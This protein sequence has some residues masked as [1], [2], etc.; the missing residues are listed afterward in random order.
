MPLQKI[1]LKPGINRENTN[2]ANE[3][4]WFNCDKVRFRS[5]YP[6]K[7]GGWIRLAPGETYQGVCRALINWF[8]LSNNNLIGVGT[9]KKYYVLPNSTSYKDITPI[10]TTKT[11]LGNPFATTSGSSIVKVTVAAHNAQVGD[12]VTFSGVPAATIG[13]IDGDLFNAE[14]EIV[15]II[16]GTEFDID[17]GE[18]ATSTATG[19]GAAVTATFQLSIG[20]PVFTIGAGWGAGVW[21]GTNKTVFATLA[22]TSGTKN[23]LLDAVST[24]IN[25]DSTTG[26]ANSGFIQINSEVI[27]YTGITATSFT[28]CTR[29]ATISG[30]ATPAT[31]HAQPPTTGS[32]TPPPIYVYQ[33][34]SSLGTTGWGLASDIAFGVGQQLR[35]WSHDTFGQ[36]LL[37][38]PRGSAIYYWQN[39]TSTYPPAVLLSTLATNAGY[40]G[41][42]V[43]ANTNQILVSDV[44]RFVIA[45]G[46]QPYGSVNF[47]PMT[48]RWS[49]Q[50]TP[51][52]WVPSAT[53]QAGE[54]RLS[55][56]SYTVCARETRQ[57]ILIW[58][59]SAIY[60]MQYLG[61]PYVWGF[62][63]LMDNIS[64]ISP[65]ATVTA[66]NIT[67][68]M[69]SDKFYIYNG[70]VDTL[71]CTVRQYIFQDLAFDQRFQITSG[72]NEG[73][74]EVW[75]FYVSKSE[76][77]RANQENRSP[78]IDKYVV[79]NYLDQVWYYGSLN[80]T[81][82]MDSGLNSTPFAARGDDDF[83][84]LVYHERGTDN[85]ETDS[86]KPIAAFIESSD[87]DIGDGHNFGFVWRMLPDVNFAGST[88]VAP[89]VD[90]TLLPRTNAGTNY[91][92][93]TSINPQTVTTTDTVI[94]VLGTDNFPNSGFLL[95]DAEII[96]YTGRTPTSFTGCTRGALGT[97]PEPHV[98]NTTVNLYNLQTNVTKSATY[99]I[100][101]FTGQIYTRVRGR[102]MAIKIS[103]TTLGT[104]WQLGAPRMDVTPDG[105]R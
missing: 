68:W 53:N 59:D 84:S 33:V 96:A 67:F 73:F 43:P 26:F 20:L 37:I 69:G 94:P 76:L 18:V 42:E 72:T 25:V 78:T 31:A 99:P 49:G 39:N 79:F 83:G 91:R 52:D 40:V 65:N 87:F 23:V 62:N 13:G 5:G 24:T 7:I 44:S 93:L 61:P 81:A 95:I 41:S 80:R 50:E 45:V 90:I 19:G 2:Y 63:L 38:N 3:G 102:Q 11:P 77:T 29:G 21:N 34:V 86:P 100:E 48:V 32:A 92:G 51:Y 104:A 16:S 60:S 98:I 66:N 75:W 36:D 58:T 27:A 35:L 12:Y 71:P 14:F 82:W 28:G 47:D 74:S 15:N 6:E 57:E 1:I 70:R 8:D 30:S 105:R 55:A 22:Y 54:Q 88:G 64:I 97:T 17:L 101:Q 4:G 103:S 56:G 9:H 46:S 10:R 85:A 89:K